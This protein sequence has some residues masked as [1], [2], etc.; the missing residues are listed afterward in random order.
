MAH[1]LPLV[2]FMTPAAR[3]IYQFEA[4][5]I[6][7]QNYHWDIDVHNHA[8]RMLDMALPYDKSLASGSSIPIMIITCRTSIS[9]LLTRR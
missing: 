4:T 8:V 7:R 5:R 2:A 9:S 1:L 3:K 6:S